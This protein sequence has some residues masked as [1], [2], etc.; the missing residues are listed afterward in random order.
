VSGINPQ[1]DEENHLQAMATRQNAEI[2][3]SCG[4]GRA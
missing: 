4:G 3:A 2:L 1:N